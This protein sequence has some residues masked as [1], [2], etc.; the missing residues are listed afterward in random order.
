VSPYDATHTSEIALSQKPSLNGKA[1]AIAGGSIGYLLVIQRIPVR[2]PHL[3]G[4]HSF[5]IQNHGPVVVC[6]SL[7]FC[8]ILWLGSLFSSAMQRPFLFW[9]C[10]SFVAMLF[11]PSPLAKLV[12]RGEP[13]VG[14]R[15][16]R[17]DRLRFV[18]LLESACCP[19]SITSARRT[20]C[21]SHN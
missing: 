8:H 19:S 17:V 16:Q 10:S 13:P 9:T 11:G 1:V 5:I 14:V 20:H 3:Q 15:F 7:P 2:W 4:Y 12:D 18:N 6:G 21:A